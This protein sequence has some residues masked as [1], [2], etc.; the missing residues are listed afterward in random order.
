MTNTKRFTQEDLLNA[1][2]LKLGDKVKIQDA[3]VEITKRDSGMIV[4]KHSNDTQ[5]KI[6]AL[7]DEDY[8]VVPQPKYTLTETEKHIVLAI[9]EKLK[10]ITR[11]SSGLLFLQIN[12]PVKMEG[13]WGVYGG[14]VADFYA[15]NHLFQFI[16][17]SD[18]EP[19]SLDE[20]RGIS[21]K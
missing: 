11:N 8:S 14:S 18:T 4:I 10:W 13:F 20:L 17:W 9:D 21:N 2:G 12:R 1:M 7:I 16:Q 5:F 19:V 6:T 15:F 3:I